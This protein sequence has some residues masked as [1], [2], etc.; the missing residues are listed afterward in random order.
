[1]QK[2]RQ[3]ILSYLS[4]H[5]QAAAEEI[6]RFLD[7]TPANIR[8]HLEILLEEGR[9]QTSGERRTGAAGRPILLYGLSGVS[10]GENLPGLAKSLLKVLFDN[11]ESSLPAQAVA[12]ELLANQERES[13]RGV[14][15]FNQAISILD[16]LGYLPNWKATREGPEIELKHCPYQD[17]ATEHPQLCQ[18]DQALLSELFQTEL[19]L[20]KRRDFGLNPYS[21]CIFSAQVPEA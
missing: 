13:L 4:D 17:L 18:I 2:T 6:A 7:L 14:Q 21:P 9:I 12:R 15:L 8:Y 19:K 1:M 3:A 16:Q 10:L 20:V 5:P 11:G